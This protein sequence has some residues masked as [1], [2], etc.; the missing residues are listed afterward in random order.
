MLCREG[1]AGA[2][3]ASAKSAFANRRFPIVGIGE[4]ILGAGE[5]RDAFERDHAP[6]RPTSRSTSGGGAVCS[7]PRAGAQQLPAVVASS[8]TTP[9]MPRICFFFASN[10]ASSMIPWSRRLASFWSSAA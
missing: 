4:A 3:L 2:R 8:N 1:Y 5:E 7:R 6:G 9:Q 10:S